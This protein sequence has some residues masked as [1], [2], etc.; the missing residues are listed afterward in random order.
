MEYLKYCPTS[1]LEPMLFKTCTTVDLVEGM[2]AEV[3]KLLATSVPRRRLLA[4]RT[5]IAAWR[6]EWVH[7]RRHMQPVK[8]LFW[9]TSGKK[10][11]AEVKAV[12]D[13][14]I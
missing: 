5:E 4:T 11:V 2:A 14:S 7:R 9:P 6:A 8:R 1:L 13:S 12:P 3:L 10:R